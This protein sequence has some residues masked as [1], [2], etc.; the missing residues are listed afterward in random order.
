MISSQVNTETIEFANSGMLHL[1]GGWP[2][3]VVPT[4]EEHKTRYKKKL[5][6]DENFVHSVLQLGSVS[7]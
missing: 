2:K 4:E 5:D 3:D 7:S 1:E 6:K